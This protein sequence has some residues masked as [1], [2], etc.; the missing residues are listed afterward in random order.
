MMM[1]DDDDDDDDEE[2]VYD[3]PE[4]SARA[5]DTDPDPSHDAAARVS[6]FLRKV[7]GKILRLLEDLGSRTLSS[8]AYEFGERG[9]IPGA[10]NSEISKLTDLK[11]RTSS[12]RM[13]PLEESGHVFRKTHRRMPLISAE[14]N[15]EDQDPQTVW[16]LITPGIVE[17]IKTD[18]A[19]QCDLSGRTEHTSAEEMG[20]A[21]IVAARFDIGHRN[22]LKVIRDEHWGEYPPPTKESMKEKNEVLKIQIATLKVRIADLEQ[23]LKLNGGSAASPSG[24]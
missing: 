13:K 19:E 3:S 10:V 20:M 8:K 5:R 16:I 12:A 23:R 9:E 24:Q 7:E 17:S 21:A 14:A 2:N 18:Y 15:K 1:D 6:P 4:Y 22:V 11:W